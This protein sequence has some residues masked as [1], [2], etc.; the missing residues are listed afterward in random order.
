MD[1]RVMDLTVGKGA[2]AIA[3]KISRK[4]LNMPRVI[5]FV[6]IFAIFLAGFSVLSCRD[7]IPKTKFEN[8][9]AKDQVFYDQFVNRGADKDH[10]TA[11]GVTL[12]SDDYP[13]EVKLFAD[14]TFYYVLPTLGDGTGTWSHSDGKVNLHAKRSLFDMSIDIHALEKGPNKVAFVFVD[15]HGWQFV[16]MN[17]HQD[18]AKIL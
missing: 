5:S 18:G 9:V 14:K 8:T 7:M 3:V 15:R 10:T 2:E 4:G 6:S 16:K 13:I 12:Q 17:L 11:T 1:K